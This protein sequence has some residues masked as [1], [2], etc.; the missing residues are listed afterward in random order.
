MKKMLALLACAGLS[1]SAFAEDAILTPIDVTPL[2]T[3]LGTW[4]TTFG[5]LL[6]GIAGIFAA[7]WLLRLA[8]RL[9]K[10]ISNTSK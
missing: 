9:I 4:A 5:T 3:A 6:L 7:F 8:I 2:K 10:S 1:V